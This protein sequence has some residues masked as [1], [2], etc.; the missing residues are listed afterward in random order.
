MLTHV[1]LKEKIVEQFTEI[2]FIES[3]NI[4]I[5]DLVNAF[6]DLIEDNHDK[7]QDQIEY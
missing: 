6:S 1:E 2:D 3:L 4:N 7:L 5:E